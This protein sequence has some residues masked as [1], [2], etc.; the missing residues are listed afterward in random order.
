MTFG[1]FAPPASFDP[2]GAAGLANGS[3]GGS[4][5]MALY[6]TVVLWDAETGKYVGR[7]AKSFEPNSDFTVWTLVLKDGI[8]FS[9]GTPYD[10]EAVKFNVERHMAETSRSQSRPLLL[11]FLKSMKVVDPLTLEFTLSKPW[12]GFP[13]LFS[14]DV[15]MI[16]SP[17]AI[18]AAGDAFGTNPGQA[19][20]GPFVLTQS[21]PGE[22]IVFDRN[23][24]Y[25]GGD[26]YLDQVTF[27][28]TAGQDAAYEAVKAG[29]LDGAYFRSATAYADAPGD[30]LVVHSALKP[31]GNVID[32][33]SGVYATCQGGQPAG[34]N[35]AADGTMVKTTAPGSDVR[36]RQAVALAID[37]DQVNQRT[38]DG[39]AAA[40][41]AL[42]QSDIPLAPSVPGPPVDAARAAQLVKEAKADGWDGS[43]RLYSVS[44][45][46]GQALG[47]SVS[48]MLTAV[49]MDV[50]LDTSFT[51]QTLLTKVIVNRDYDLVIWGSAFTENPDGNFVSFQGSFG[52]AASQRGFRGFSSDAMDAGIAAL[53]VA[54]THDADHQGVRDAR[55][56]VERRG[57][58]RV[59]QPARGRGDHPAGGQ[60]RPGDGHGDDG[61]RRRLA[62]PLRSSPP[63]HRGRPRRLDEE[64]Q[65]RSGG[66]AVLRLIGNKLLLLVPVLFLVTA[67]TFLLVEMVPGDPATQ[68]LGPN[69]TQADYQ[70]IRSGD[71]ARR[72]APESLPGLDVRCRAPPGPRPATWSHRWSRS[73]SGC[74]VPCRSTSSSWS[75]RSP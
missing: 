36:V 52:S 54:G 56:G 1:E 58:R 45:E 11:S 48:A 69:S 49:G 55:P 68:V 16:A 22:A 57:A 33:N 61:A 18:A 4:E 75:S 71:G 37:A 46:V 64:R 50:A 14:I 43:I 9:D 59:A 28:P 65:R 62:R 30:G 60:G 27:V 29:E 13:Y 3:V 73:R 7:T 20:A 34:C 35:G 8:K 44:D 12:A 24:N 5:L 67:G 31:A 72:A 2:T 42:F 23:P 26:V 25:Y 74:S 53:Q 63:H 51:P 47:L 19:G 15:G 6:D 32:I 41:K 39:A 21:R 10:A 70:R 38:Y 40:G 17:T 66:D